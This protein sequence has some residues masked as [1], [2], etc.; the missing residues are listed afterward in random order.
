MTRRIL[1]LVLLTSL[2]LATTA[3]A[4]DR[5]DGHVSLNTTG[6]ERPVRWAPRQD[7]DAAQLIITTD[8]RDAELVLN[9]DVVAL[10]L[11]ERA[12]KRVRHELRDADKKAEENENCA[13]A[14]F[15]SAILSTVSSFLDHS[16]ECPLRSIRD[17][18]YVDGRLEFTTQDGRRM[19]EHVSV[20][21]R[22]VM[23]DF[24]E[25]DAR[26]FVTEFHRLKA[27]AR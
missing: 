22:D 23:G 26:Q 16:A 15:A 20:D 1:L 5:H 12:L 3:R 17:V 8:H 9:S 7:P 11:S 13:G 25:S 6:V 4:G 14:W 21:S 2:V 10:Q 24:S 27:H 19:F 18:A